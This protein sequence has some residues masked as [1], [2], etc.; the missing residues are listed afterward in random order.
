V[1]NPEALPLAARGRQEQQALEN[2]ANHPE[3]F[4]HLKSNGSNDHTNTNANT[5][6]PRHRKSLQSHF[7]RIGEKLHGAW[8]MHTTGSTNST[9]EYW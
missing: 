8:R 4:E 3:R 2:I 5:N 7:L 9:L 6:N 1:R